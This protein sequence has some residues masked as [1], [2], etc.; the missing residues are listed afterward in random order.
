VKEAV[1]AMLVVLVP[2]HAARLSLQP[3]SVR[4]LA[5][6]GVTSLTLLQGDTAAA[7]VLEGWAFD[8]GH[9]AAA[10]V[11]A[12]GAAPGCATTLQPLTQLTLAP[13]S[14]HAF[15]RSGSTLPC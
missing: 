2:E 5:E 4:R 10:A 13:Q 6:L 3:P 15:P 9:S 7:I 1:V 8:P 11:I 12:L 14:D